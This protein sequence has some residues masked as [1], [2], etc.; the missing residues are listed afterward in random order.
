MAWSKRLK[1]IAPTLTAQALPEGFTERDVRIESSVCTGETII[2]FFDRSENKLM[3][4][5]LVQS[6][7]DIDRFYKKYG[8]K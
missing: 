6:E 1:K 8:L 5:E 4:A 3:Y 2:G 7:A